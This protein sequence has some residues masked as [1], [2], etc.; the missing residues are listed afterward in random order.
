MSVHKRARLYFGYEDSTSETSSLQNVW[1]SFPW[2]STAVTTYRASGDFTVSDDGGMKI[3]YNRAEPSWFDLDAVCNVYK[4]AGGN[5]NRNI[6]MVWHLNDSPAGPARGSYMNAQDSQ[7]LTGCG[8]VYLTQGDELKP[9]CR[10][11]EN[12]DKL[13]FKCCTFDFKED[14]D[15][16]Y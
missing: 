4:G 15:Y 5:A 16:G 6:E 3:T 11:I 7:L 2:P 10:N 12:D 8:Q 13:C 14:F 9:K 1:E